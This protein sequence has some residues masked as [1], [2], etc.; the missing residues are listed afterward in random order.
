MLV[1]AIS[2][3]G[4]LLFKCQSRPT[5]TT[6]NG[7][8]I[9]NNCDTIYQYISIP[10]PQM[11]FSNTSNNLPKH[12]MGVSLGYDYSIFQK[13]G[14]LNYGLNYRYKKFIIGG[15]YN[16]SLGHFGLRAG[17]QFEGDSLQ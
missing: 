11:T 8:S 7:I 17:F 1:A 6:Q 13:K 2:I 3:M 16:N 9:V 15:Y 4:W 12:G 5:T 14:G 10:N